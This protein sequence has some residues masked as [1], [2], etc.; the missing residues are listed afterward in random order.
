M[1]T[2]TAIKELLDS[3]KQARNLGLRQVQLDDILEHI[4]KFQAKELLNMKFCFMEGRDFQAESGNENVY[5]EKSAD[6]FIQE[7]YTYYLWTL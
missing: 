7:N 4:K 2:D 5:F 1:R 6:D 3:L